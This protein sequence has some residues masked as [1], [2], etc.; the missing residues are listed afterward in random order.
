MAT[1]V[2][3]GHAQLDHAKAENSPSG[4]SWASLLAQARLGHLACLTQGEGEFLVYDAGGGLVKKE[5]Y[6]ETT[7]Y[8][9]QHYEK[10]VTTGD[11]V[12]YYYHNGQRVAMRKDG[13]LCYIVG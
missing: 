8:V 13:V 4:Y 11:K 9:G 7:H 10:N 2:A 5:V 1:T 12:L 3:I 6:G